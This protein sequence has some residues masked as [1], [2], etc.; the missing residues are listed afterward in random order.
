M[1]IFNPES[2]VVQEFGTN[3]GM[4]FQAQL[5]QDLL[6]NK[7]IIVESFRKKDVIEGVL[8]K[9]CQILGE[10]GISHAVIERLRQGK[11]CTLR[12]RDRKIIID[13]ILDSI[14][15]SI[16]KQDNLETRKGYF[17]RFELY[18][19][20]SIV[21]NLYE[22][23]KIQIVGNVIQIYSRSEILVKYLSDKRFLGLSRRI[24]IFNDSKV[25]TGLTLNVIKEE[26]SRTGDVRRH[27]LWHAFDAAR[28][29]ILG[30]MDNPF[31]RPKDYITD[32][33][34]LFDKYYDL[35]QQ[36][37]LE[38]L[39]YVFGKDNKIPSPRD[40]YDN[41][42]S[43][44][45]ELPAFLAGNIRRNGRIEFDA[46]E[47][48]DTLIENYLLESAVNLKELRRICSL[49]ESGRLVIN[50]QVILSD[51]NVKGDYLRS[52]ID[53][54]D[55]FV[56]YF[57][58]VDT[59]SQRRNRKYKKGMEENLKKYYQE[60]VDFF[61]NDSNS[62]VFQIRRE[63][64]RAIVAFKVRNRKVGPYRA[65]VEMSLLPINRWAAYVRSKESE[66]SKN[67]PQ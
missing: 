64:H 18:N 50:T 34:K 19:V 56:R 41:M 55:S 14:N 30:T 48:V 29:A 20:E 44:H 35:L 22:K 46:E 8:T 66:E 47:I 21:K 40:S 9:A 62:E 16:Y 57:T 26:Q 54:E 15:A 7:G 23:A 60:V 58:E 45:I 25:E 4:D 1:V 3:E 27:E 42:K 11:I 5:A 32:P 36:K 59:Q 12:E 28:F 37:P 43:L 38:F 65:L 67:L 49:Y 52:G 2:E 17:S 24:R 51:I 33:K 31:Y 10:I 53:E 39:N 63:L 13:T 61:Y 6:N